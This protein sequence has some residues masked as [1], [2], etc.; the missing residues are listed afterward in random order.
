MFIALLL[1]NL[2]AYTI[3]AIATSLTSTPYVSY[4]NK[5]RAND[6]ECPLHEQQ[7]D[8]LLPAPAI[9]KLCFIAN[10]LL[11]LMSGALLVNAFLWWMTSVSEISVSV[12]NYAL[13]CGIGAGIVGLVLVHILF[14]KK[15]VKSGGLLMAINTILGLT[16]MGL[17]FGTI[18]VSR[19]WS[20]DSS[21]NSLEKGGVE[22]DLRG[23]FMQSLQEDR[24]GQAHS[25]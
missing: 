6:C 20:V 8:W 13:G 25:E 10:L 9:T 16:L 3:T 14:I 5:L 4:S 12:R 18:G 7:Q 24:S 23:V 1:F 22:L 11:G 21:Q 15:L 19:A 17:A 2:A